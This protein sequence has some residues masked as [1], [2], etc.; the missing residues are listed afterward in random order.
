MN[1]LVI[2]DES[3]G[4]LVI[5]R[6]AGEDWLFDSFQDALAWVTAR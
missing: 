6:V 5:D 3:D 4:V 1:K 2:E